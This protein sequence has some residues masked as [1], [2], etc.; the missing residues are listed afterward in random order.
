MLRSDL[1]TFVKLLM[2]GGQKIIN[3]VFIRWSDLSQTQPFAFVCEG[4]LVR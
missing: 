2:I 4:G 1:Q 3:D